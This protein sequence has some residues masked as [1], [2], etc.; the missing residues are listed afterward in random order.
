MNDRM[1][2]NHLNSVYSVLSSSMNGTGSIGLLRKGVQLTLMLALVLSFSIDNSFAQDRIE[3]TGTVTDAVDGSGLPGASI[4][5]QGSEEA[6]GSTIG[7]T[8]DMDGNFTIRVPENLNTLTVSF[9]GYITQN[10]AIDGRTTV[11]V[12]L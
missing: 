9:I 4:I 10:V 1:L 7:T 5:V 2:R 6:T 11:N 8:T 3:I 12:Q